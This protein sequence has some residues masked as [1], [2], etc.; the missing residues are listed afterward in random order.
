MATKGEQIRGLRDFF[1]YAFTASEFEMFLTVNGYREVALAVNQN[2]G[3]IAYFYNVAQEFDRRGLIDD[4]FFD[5]LRQE[6][7]R[8]GPQISAL[9]QL[10]RGEDPAGPKPSGSA[11]SADP[12]Q[13]ARA[14]DRAAPV[15]KLAGFDPSDMATFVTSI[16][17][18]ARRVS[19]HGTVSEQAAEL[20]RWAESS[21]GPASRRSSMRSRIFSGPADR[22][23]SPSQGGPRSGAIPLR[24]W[25]WHR[26]R[27]PRMSG[28]ADRQDWVPGKARRGREGCPPADLSENCPMPF[29]TWDCSSPT[30]HEGW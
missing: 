19:R 8:K 30:P 14:I 13:P 7:P 1:V 9:Q 6:R 17:G 29:G 15:R 2:A 21:T 27:P 11:T 24:R 26:P 23:R 3:S 22:R 28:L 18:A 5:Q 20:I 4:A 16:E 12:P 25:L 10:W